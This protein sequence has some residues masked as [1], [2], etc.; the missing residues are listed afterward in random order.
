VA[1]FAVEADPGDAIGSLAVASHGVSTL[2]PGLLFDDEFATFTR[3]QTLMAIYKARA[4][5]QRWMATR[6][7]G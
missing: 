5:I 2:N 4:A 6:T 1:K 3:L 7:P